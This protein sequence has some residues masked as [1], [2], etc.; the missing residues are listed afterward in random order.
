M[1]ALAERVQNLQTELCQSEQRREEL[2]AELSTA[3]EVSET[4]V[5]RV[6]ADPSKVLK[7]IE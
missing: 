2:E 3:Q 7:D 4:L 6:P 5:F 1:A